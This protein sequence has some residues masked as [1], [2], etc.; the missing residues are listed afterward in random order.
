MRQFEV[1]TLQFI[2]DT[3]TATPN[4]TV[5][6]LAVTV[7]TQEVV[8]P[9]PEQAEDGAEN[10]AS[11]VGL[12]VAF[13]TVGVVT[14]GSAP[15]D[16]DFTS[17]TDA[18]FEHYYGEYLYR[19]SISD[20]FFEPLSKHVDTTT[21]LPL[22]EQAEP[23]EGEDPHSQSQFVVAVLFASFALVLA[24]SGSVFAVRKH[25][26][27]ESEKL[28]RLEYPAHGTKTMSDDPDYEE[29]EDRA[30]RYD[31]EEL[32]DLSATQAESK[33]QTQ[34]IATTTRSLQL[35]I[36]D[37]GIEMEDIGLTPISVPHVNAFSS[38]HKPPRV[39]VSPDA[40]ERGGRVSDYGNGTGVFMDLKKRASFGFGVKKWLTPRRQSSPKT[41]SK[42]DLNDPPEVEITFEAN[43]EKP[44]NKNRQSMDPDAVKASTRN[45][46]GIITDEQMTHDELR[47]KSEASNSKRKSSSRDGNNFGVPVSFFGRS[48][49][50]RSD[51]TSGNMDSMIGGSTASSFLRMGRKSNDFTGRES[52]QSNIGTRMSEQEANTYKFGSTSGRNTI[53]NNENSKPG[54]AFSLNEENLAVLRTNSND[55]VEASVAGLSDFEMKR[56]MFE[57]SPVSQIFASKIARESRNVDASTK[58]I[59]LVLNTHDGQDSSGTE[60]EVK[61]TKTFEADSVYSEQSE[62]DLNELGIETMLGGIPPA[63]D[64]GTPASRNSSFVG[65]EYGSRPIAFYPPSSIGAPSEG[66][67]MKSGRKSDATLGARALAAEEAKRRISLNTA[68]K[69][70]DTYDVFAPA[71]PIGIVV[72]TSKLGPAVHSLKSTSPMLGLINPGDLIIALDDEDTRNMTAASLTRLMAKKSRQRERKITLLAPNG[73]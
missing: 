15:R 24:V 42:I 17:V 9:E 16:L 21:L 5:S 12:Q 43:D 41:T 52:T 3:Q 64:N 6:L 8:Y 51:A 2:R 55:N 60:R 70:G 32:S 63:Y 59:E 53:A 45:A 61:R 25:L 68:I 19:L 47:T 22:P 34:R 62:L 40:M 1:T 38:A 72:D 57:G 66:L 30:R 14:E 37:E 11:T 69:Q 73:F 58:S 29:Q 67:S 13:R 71:G 31:C 20:S 10:N 23:S 18:G 7:L 35:D 28:Q 54:N 27:K 36:D 44:A 39:P 26:R 50:N 56:A 46:A 33:H 65:H 4:F 49:D 48:S